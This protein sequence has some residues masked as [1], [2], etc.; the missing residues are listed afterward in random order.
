MRASLESQLGTEPCLIEDTADMFWLRESDDY[1]SRFSLGNALAAQY[2]FKDAIEAYEKATWI[3]QD[4]WKI[5]YSLGG[6]YLTI[7]YFDKAM[8]TYNRCI[9]LGANEA[10]VAFPLGIGCY[11]QNDYV[12]AMTWFEKCLP[13]ENEMAIAVIYWHTLSSY[14]SGH[15]PTLLDT[16]HQNMEVGHHTAYQ[17]AVSVFC[18][19]TKWKKVLTQIENETDDLNYVIALYGLCVYLEQVGEVT[20]SEYYVSDLLK[21]ECVWPC[22][23]YLAAWND[24]IRKSD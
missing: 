22:V 7:R 9:A 19:E 1:Q 5:F 11:L 6:A 17:L 4:D 16:Y 10:T 18:G 3:R 12:S 23:S 2:R 20:K 14:R 21:R 24:A 13:C 8:A 15:K